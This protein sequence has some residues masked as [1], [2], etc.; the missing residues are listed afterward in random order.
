MSRSSQKRAR[1]AER[2]SA[3]APAPAPRPT[4]T[5][6]KEEA[7]EERVAAAVGDVPEDW[8]D[9]SR[10]VE[11]APMGADDTAVMHQYIQAAL[12][13]KGVQRQ[14]EGKIKPL[15][16]AETEAKRT[17]VSKLVDRAEA[18]ARAVGDYARE[19]VK[20]KGIHTFFRI[21]EATLRREDTRRGEWKGAAFVA[22]KFVTLR[23]KDLSE[24]V[25]QD[26]LHAMR[27][28][29]VEAEAAVARS[30]LSKVRRAT[31]TQDAL[32]RTAFM[33]VFSSH[34]QRTLN[35]QGWDLELVAALPKS[36]EKEVHKHGTTL[37]LLPQGEVFDAWIVYARARATCRREKH[38][39]AASIEADTKQVKALQAQ[40]LNIMLATKKSSRFFSPLVNGV[41]TPMFVR[42]KPKK[43]EYAKPTKRA[44]Y[45]H[46]DHF[47]DDAGGL[48]A[49]LD[50]EGGESAARQAAVG[51][52]VDAYKRWDATVRTRVV[53]PERLEVGLD[54]GKGAS[55]A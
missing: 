44:F 11:A 37:P 54:Y 14:E 31:T 22:L 43:A 51:A 55:R 3:S 20:S 18:R 2:A 35:T 53:K 30:K 46:V 5:R 6:R 17:F 32:M 16:D 9:L 10:D 26:V 50:E 8:N 24:E 49:L 40:I 15:Q 39:K 34:I 4:K 25:I 41:A 33:T 19:G 27:R 28:Q 47:V 21:P 7:L 23:S 48:S 38:K 42:V 36:I 45:K 52:F 13:V 1:S 29:E 12:H